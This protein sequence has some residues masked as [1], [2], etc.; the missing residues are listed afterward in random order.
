MRWNAK[1]AGKPIRSMRDGY[2]IVKINV[3]GESSSAPAHMLA[4][5]LMTGK[6]PEDLIDHAD[7]D[8]LNNK[9]TNLR[10]ATDAQNRANVG[11]RNGT[12]STFKGVYWSA[13]CEKWGA[14]IDSGGEREYLGLYLTEIEAA[15]AYDVAAKRLHG[16]FACLNGVGDVPINRITYKLGAS[17][18]RGVS[19]HK[20]GWVAKAAGRYIG[21]Y[22]TVEL[23]T[24]AIDKA[25]ASTD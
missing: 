7:R 18:V 22:D 17:G 16:A 15:A 5:A 24:E 2:I 8:C 25:L 4:A 12:T 13:E 11:K 23:A 19:R 14:A 6:W 10:E 1:H 9:W 20:G 3:N 21:L